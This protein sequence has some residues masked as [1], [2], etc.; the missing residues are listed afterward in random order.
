MKE[1]KKKTKNQGVL[2]RLPEDIVKES[3]DKAEEL[4]LSYNAYLR[5][6]LTRY[7]NEVSK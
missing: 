6:I 1:R 4:N 3:K 7:F 5:L 2:L